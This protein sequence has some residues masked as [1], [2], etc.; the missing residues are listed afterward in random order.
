MTNDERILESLAVAIELC[1]GSSWSKAAVAAVCVQLREYPIEAVLA[2]LQR[3]CREVTGRL[4][5]AAIIE[6]IDDGRPTADEAWAQVGTDDEAR[7]LVSTNEAMAALGEVRDLLDDDPV[8]ARMAFK[9]SYKRIVTQS[10]AEG[11]APEWFASLGHDPGGRTAPITQAVERGRL[12]TDY[13]QRLLGH[14][15]PVKALPGAR[16]VDQLGQ[17][18]VQAL[19]AGL[20]QG[21]AL[22]GDERPEYTPPNAEEVAEIRRG[23]ELA[24]KATA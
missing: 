6:R 15:F 13:A 17:K 12:T 16:Q 10:R 23:V 19:L 3:C 20:S 5:L 2:A 4:S 11:R 1:G 8:A 7:T 22:P 18:R 9:D 21:L 14:H 24:K